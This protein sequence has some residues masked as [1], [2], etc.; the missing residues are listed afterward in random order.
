MEI[1]RVLFQTQATWLRV[2]IDTSPVLERLR[3]KT[4]EGDQPGEAQLSLPTCT[5]RKSRK[6][7]LPTVALTLTKGGTRR[8]ISLLN[9]LQQWHK[10]KGRDTLVPEA[11]L[12]QA[13]P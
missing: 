6:T 3:W 4:T 8:P 12:V 2:D 5:L 9:Y 13:V 1:L 7:I 10:K 11:H